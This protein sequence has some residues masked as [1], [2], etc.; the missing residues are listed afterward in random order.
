M[1]SPFQEQQR[2]SRKTHSAMSLRLPFRSRWKLGRKNS[3]GGSSQLPRQDYEALRER[4]L[5]E[6]RL[7]ED[8][9]FPASLCSV[10]SG[11][12]LRKLPPGLQ[13][14]RPPVREEGTSPRH[15]HG[16]TQNLPWEV[17]QMPGF[18]HCQ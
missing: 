4:C 8:D 9:S 17:F 5:M 18:T 15:T 13:W 1:G 3:L 12:L 14:R 7:F 16:S 10:G 6:D 11:P 2:P